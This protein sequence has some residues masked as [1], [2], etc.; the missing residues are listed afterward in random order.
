MVNLTIDGNPVTVPEGTTILQAAE[1][2]GYD[3][4]Q[5]CYHPGLDIVGVCRVCLV[6]VEGMPKLVPSC[7]TQVREGME[8]GLYVEEAEKA[9]RGV[10]EFWLLNHPLDCPICD[11]GVP[12]IP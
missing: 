1:R 7:A 11:Q 6:K 9:R 2:L 5:M 8:V 10:I 4:P 12:K 3:V